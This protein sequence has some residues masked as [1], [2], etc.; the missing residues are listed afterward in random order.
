PAAATNRSRAASTEPT[1]I[2]TWAVGGTGLGLLVG[3][4]FAGMAAKTAGDAYNARLSDPQN[5]PVT[6][7]SQ[8]DAAQSMGSKA[9]LLTVTG[10]VLLA[11]G[12]ALYF[13][14]PQLFGGGSGSGVSVSA[15]PVEGGGAVAVASRF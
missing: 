8:Y 3:G 14:E 4:L 11:G 1:R 6:L 12:V 5:N 13:F 7:K 9:T 2:W 10:T 15:A